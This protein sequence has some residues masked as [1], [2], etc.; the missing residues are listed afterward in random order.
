MSSHWNMNF[1][2]QELL[3][4]TEIFHSKCQCYA[5]L[6]FE[7]IMAVLNPCY[8]VPFPCAN[9]YRETGNEWKKQAVEVILVSLFI[10]AC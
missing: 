8:C 10:I 4:D 2:T 5:A 3:H 9:P 6:K 7:A 1:R